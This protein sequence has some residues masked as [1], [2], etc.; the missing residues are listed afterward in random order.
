LH[1]FVNISPMPN[2]HI[3]YCED[4]KIVWDEICN[5]YEAKK[6]KTSRSPMKVCH[7]QDAR[8]RWHACA[9]QHGE[10]ACGPF[11]EVN[12]K[13]ENIY[14]IFLMSLP[15][16]FDNLVKSLKSMSTKDIYFQ[17]I[18]IKLFYDFQKKGVRMFGKCDLIKQKSKEKWQILF[19]LQGTMSFCKELFKKEKWW[20]G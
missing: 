15:L 17:F 6:L 13:Y 16:V 1:S 19:L 3:Q 4:V 10:S 18:V 2:F 9:H 11:N 8:R 7:H 14:M 12:I 20:E 5:V